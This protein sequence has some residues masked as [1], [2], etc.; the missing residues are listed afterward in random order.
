MM[1]RVVRA[2]RTAWW[3]TGSLMGDHDY[4]RYVE[5]LRRNHPDAEVPTER[6]YWKARYADADANPGARCC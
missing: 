5:H 1:N 3:W 6:E 2:V 4:S